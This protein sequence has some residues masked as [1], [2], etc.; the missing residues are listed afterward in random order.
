MKISK[1][2]IVISTTFFTVICCFSAFSKPEKNTVIINNEAKIF[3]F[4][5]TASDFSAKFSFLLL[6]GN[7]VVFRERQEIKTEDSIL[8]ELEKQ[9]LL[10]EQKR[11]DNILGRSKESHTQTHSPT[12]LKPA[13]D[14][15][16]FGKKSFVSVGAG[17][18]NY[19]QVDNINST[20]QP[21]LFFSFGA[22]GY[23]G[24]FNFL[25]CLVIILDTILIP[26]IEIMSFFVKWLISRRFLWL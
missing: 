1:K 23:K 5:R 14:D 12:S 6:Q 3:I 2:L 15:W 7:F 8:K 26:S 19:Y 4:S 24:F 10:D 17:F 25:N 16:F 18:V 21:A 11:V 13:W 20:E 9:R 22:Y